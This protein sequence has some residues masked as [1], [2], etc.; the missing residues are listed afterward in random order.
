M[1]G[2]TGQDT[3]IFVGGSGN[4]GTNLTDANSATDATNEADVITDFST[5]NDTIDLTKGNDSG[6]FLADNDSA[7][8]IVINLD[9]DA[10]NWDTV[11]DRAEA[12]F[13][14]G[15][16][17]YVSVDAFD[18]GNAYVFVDSDDSGDLSDND[19]VIILTGIDKTTEISNDDFSI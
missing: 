9:N 8:D 16:D 4:D 18:S 6:T 1:T 15:N 5:G 13:T 10:A 19:I 3:F 2:G 17:V 7:N 11:V 14:T 12:V